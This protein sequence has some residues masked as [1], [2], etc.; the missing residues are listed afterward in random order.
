MNNLKKIFSLFLLFLIILIFF[1]YN[2]ILSKTVVE[3]T[4]IWLTKV[5]PSLFIMFIINEIIIKTKALELLNKLIG[6][7]FN[8]LWH[9]TSSSSLAFILS[10]FSGT[11][12]NA[13]I[14]KE[15]LEDAQITLE[16]ANKLIY[17][18]YFPNPLFL[19][20]ILNLSF[21]QTITLKI[22]MTLFISNLII[23]FLVR[24]NK[25]N[26]SC[27]PKPNSS[28][29]NLFFILPTAIKKSLNTLLMILGSIIFY[30]II[31]NLLL[32]IFK[33]NLSLEIL[34][35]GFL[36]ISNALNTLP[37]LNTLSIKKEIIALIIISFAGLS[38]HTQ[39]LEILN[40]T[41]IAYSHFLKGRLYQILI[42]TS[43]Y[44]LISIIISN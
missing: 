19:Y 38:I 13:Y 28:K 41:K 29:T 1:K 11:P 33:L 42:S 34:L 26:Y 21:N 25:P 30:L 18:T 43:T 17:Y 14:L 5:F 44:L 27:N 23:A 6:P 9:I 31:S 24:G 39:V 2:Y 16:D 20:T 32:T 35:K 10:I 7:L 15:M 36:E 22:I 37:L 40:E 3:A 12:G 8:K 4:N